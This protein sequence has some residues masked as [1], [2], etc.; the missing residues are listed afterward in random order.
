VRTEIQVKLNAAGAEESPTE[1]EARSLEW[2]ME[3]VKGQVTD[4]DFSQVGAP[5]WQEL[6]QMQEPSPEKVAAVFKG[7]GLTGDQAQTLSEALAWFHVVLDPN[8]ATWDIR[9]WFD[10]D[11]YPDL[12]EMLE[13]VK[14]PPADMT[15][16]KFAH[17]TE[18]WLA[19]LQLRFP[20]FHPSLKLSKERY[21]TPTELWAQVL[22]L[23]GTEWFSRGYL[24]RPQFDALVPFEREPSR[25]YQTPAGQQAPFYRLDLS[26]AL[27]PVTAFADRNGIFWNS[28]LEQ[29][30]RGEY[31][32]YR[33]GYLEYQRTGSSPAIRT[34]SDWLR[35]TRFGRFET[36]EEA[37][38]VWREPILLEEGI[39]YDTL[40]FL[41]SLVGH[42][43]RWASE[44]QLIVEKSAEFLRSSGAAAERLIEQPRIETVAMLLEAEA[45]LGVLSASSERARVFFYLLREGRDKGGSERLAAV[46]FL[47]PVLLRRLGWD[48]V[49]ESEVTWTERMENWLI[50]DPEEFALFEQSLAQA[51]QKIQNEWFL[52]TEERKSVHPLPWGIHRPEP[53][54][55]AGA[56]EEALL[57][58]GPQEVGA[59]RKLL[60]ELGQIPQTL[61]DREKWEWVPW[62]DN[63]VVRVGPLWKEPTSSRAPVIVI[64]TLE[65]AAW[66]PEAAAQ[67]FGT[68]ENPEASRKSRRW[69]GRLRF[70]GK[71]SGRQRGWLSAERESNGRLILTLQAGSL[72]DLT[73]D[74]RFLW[75]ALAYLARPEALAIPRDAVPF[76]AGWLHGARQIAYDS[77]RQDLFI[78]A[79]SALIR[80]D[81]VTGQILSR[82][83]LQQT[84][85]R[86]AG[87]YLQMDERRGEL[88][89]L[90]AARASIQIYRL[91]PSTGELKH[92]LS[93]EQGHETGLRVSGFA[94]DS[95][96]ETL[97]ILENENVVA[98]NARTGEK[99]KA[100]ELSLNN[101]LGIAYDPR[102]RRVY[103]IQKNHQERFEWEVAAFDLRTGRPTGWAVPFE[104]TPQQV[105]YDA[106]LDRVM[107]LGS[108][109]LHL[110][111]PESER[112]TSPLKE[113]LTQP[114]AVAHDPRTRTFF[115]AEE[116]VLP[117]GIS[118][119]R[120]RAF[121]S[122]TG[123]PAAVPR[124]ESRDNP[125]NLHREHAPFFGKPHRTLQFSLLELLARKEADGNPVIRRIEVGG[126][127]LPLRPEP[128]DTMIEVMRSLEGQP[129]LFER[130][131]DLLTITPQPSPAAG[132]E[133]GWARGAVEIAAEAVQGP[134]VVVIDAAM[135]ARQAG[136]EEL[137]KRLPVENRIVVVGVVEGSA[138]MQEIRAWNGQIRFADS[139]EEA[140]PLILSLPAA[141][142]VSILAADAFAQALQAD[143]RQFTIE[144]FHLDHRLG[145]GVLLVSLG[146][147]EGVLLQLDWTSVKSALSSLEAA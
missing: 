98:V 74:L 66:D 61:S 49:R 50:A 9:Q 147:P 32:G 139:L 100:L 23:V 64:A 84:P 87:F 37:M 123:A 65:P 101:P 75:G 102:R 113:M 82:W 48:P 119:G 108:D 63:G 115:L 143:L 14:D 18:K 145:L 124:A 62:L 79:G 59:Y 25:Y 31:L 41:E 112:L 2:L 4:F 86:G 96:S 146:V 56:E 120:V 133:E 5:V 121:S 116:F 15:P 68:S 93:S 40:A 67:L 92:L 127:P 140:V 122:L 11:F 24:Y 19:D 95:A 42:R 35:V 90:E 103:V 10:E 1:L 114:R 109:G 22:E 13:I 36:V 73:K 131:G 83:S 135:F 57:R 138:A 106:A 144:A 38:R 20:T 142:V 46:E 17:Y 111:D 29:I 60:G 126:A 44:P 107:I 117:S 30:F 80:M 141:D 21:P 69:Q 53:A 128:V 70:S 34:F 3:T 43:L 78:V 76:Q 105:S 77:V 110:A 47:L 52:T 91:D 125:V 33:A 54:L 104:G 81:S 16:E 72:Q 99:K 88:L 134:G 12:A 26:E 8:S 129:A 51:A 130:A 137:L 85:S 94:Y 28:H 118:L 132:A 58:M 97:L 55:A 136:L 39:H 6:M 89:L 27:D 7:T 45:L 71:M